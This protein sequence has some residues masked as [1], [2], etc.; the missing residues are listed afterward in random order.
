[1]ATSLVSAVIDLYNS[2]P[3]GTFGG[4]TRPPIFMG[5]AAQTTA[6]AVQQRPPYVVLYDESQ[7]PEFDSSFGG[8]ERGELRLE[9]FAVP[10]GAA[11]GISVD[12]IVAA[13]KWGGSNPAAKAGLDFG[14]FVLSG[15]NYKIQ[16]QRTREQRSYA[17]FDFEGQRVHKC[18][19]RYAVILGLSPT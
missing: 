17:G 2:I 19:L 6:A 7:R 5:K 15:Y 13:V 11:S 16:I 1:M 10:L 8:I 9:V 4:A 3:A 12:S 14:A 18:E